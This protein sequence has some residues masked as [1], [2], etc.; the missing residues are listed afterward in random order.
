MPAAYPRMFSA[1]KRNNVNL[2]K[3]TMKDTINL[4]CA[5][6]A[7]GA[8]VAVLIKHLAYLEVK[9][10]SE[11]WKDETAR[12]KQVLAL[13]YSKYDALKDAAD[14]VPMKKFQTSQFRMVH[15]KVRLV[16]GPPIQAPDQLKAEA[17]CARFGYRLE[18]EI[19]E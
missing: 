4:V 12:I 11:F 6:I 9:K 7:A 2:N 15:G 14:G 3:K 13:S 17:I 19:K 18:S 5:L 10:T 16:K 1:S 8:W